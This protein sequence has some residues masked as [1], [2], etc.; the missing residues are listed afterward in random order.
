VDPTVAE[1]LIDAIAGGAV[2]FASRQPGSS[3]ELDRE[4]LP[5]VLGEEEGVPVRHPQATRCPC[6][7]TAA[8]PRPLTPTLSPPTPSNPFEPV[9]A[10]GSAGKHG[11]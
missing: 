8:S 2:L 11:A 4:L 7:G 5:D 9:R 10:A 3:D 6:G 1:R